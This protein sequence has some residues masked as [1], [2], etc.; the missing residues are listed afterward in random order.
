MF[1]LSEVYS[2]FLAAVA[3][4]AVLNPFGNLPQF[5]AMTEEMGTPVRQALFRNILYTSFIIVLVF[6]LSGQVIMTYLFQIDIDDLRIAGGLILVIMAL[7]SLLLHTETKNASYYQNLSP[8][9]LLSHSVVPMAFPMLVGPG[10]LSTVIVIAEERGLVTTT[11]AVILCF[12]FMLVLF[13]YAAMIERVL[14][15]L[16][17]HVLSRIAMVFIMAMGV[18]MMVAGIKNLF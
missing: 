18:K 11:L 4:L 8:K 13:H 15:K 3:V 16:V 14:G 17:L 12:A 7:K 2:I 5:I 9:E 6:L 1:N 10:T